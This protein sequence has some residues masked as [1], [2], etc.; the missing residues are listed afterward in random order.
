MRSPR[1][2]RQER[3]CISTSFLDSPSA[4]ICQ[5]GEV[6]G[7]A[8]THHLFT[9]PC[10]AQSPLA[11]SSIVDVPKL[12]PMRSRAAEGS[13]AAEGGRAVVHLLQRSKVA[14]SPHSRQEWH[15][16][17]RPV[18]SE[19]GLGGRQQARRGWRAID[20]QGRATKACRCPIRL[21]CHRVRG[22]D[23]G[24]RRPSNAGPAPYL[25]SCKIR[26]QCVLVRYRDL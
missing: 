20:F 23:K 6:Y 14:A 9:G 13:S 15:Q 18:T 19:T 25:S 3:T 5:S 7:A 22:R 8:I 4:A 1:I 11:M 24:S 16:S 21:A 10:A 26:S 12:P 2:C 17:G